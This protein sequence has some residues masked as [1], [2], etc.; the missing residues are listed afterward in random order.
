[1]RFSNESDALRRQIAIKQ[2]LI[3][4]W[5]RV[6]FYSDGLIHVFDGRQRKSRPARAHDDWCH[7]DM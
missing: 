7:D 2:H 5:M 4:K 3:F 1:M 6:H